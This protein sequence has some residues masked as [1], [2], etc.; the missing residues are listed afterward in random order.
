LV[1]DI[2]SQFGWKLNMVTLLYGGKVISRPDQNPKT[3]RLIDIGVK[4][5]DN[6]I[7]LQRSIGGSAGNS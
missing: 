4:K 5:M 7:I 1:K 3:T 2:G 6:F